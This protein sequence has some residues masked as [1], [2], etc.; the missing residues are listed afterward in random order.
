MPLITIS[1]HNQKSQFNMRHLIVYILI[2]YF[3]P[4]DQVETVDHQ[5][6]WSNSLGMNVRLQHCLRSR[7]RTSM[8]GSSLLQ[9]AQRY[10]PSCGVKVMY[11]VTLLPQTA[12][13]TPAHPFKFIQKR[14]R[15]EETVECISP[16]P[17][18]IAHITH[19]I[20]FP[21]RD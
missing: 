12:V 10:Q 6:G 3:P 19:C 20:N 21:Q 15:K 5:E 13:V 7:V 17:Q 16:K 14:K 4:F 2:D 18:N 11:V 9:L 1:P 8:A